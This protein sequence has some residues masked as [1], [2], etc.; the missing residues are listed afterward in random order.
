MNPGESGRRRR[1]SGATLAYLAGVSAGIA[2]ICL[3]VAVPD[4]DPALARTLGLSGAAPLAVLIAVPTAG[5]LAGVTIAVIKR[6]RPGIRLAGSVSLGLAWLGG[7][8]TVYATATVVG[9]LV[10]SAYL[11]HIHFAG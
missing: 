6:L 7:C 2:A 4:L 8:V 5:V 1:L 10:L 9:L 3:S 11:R